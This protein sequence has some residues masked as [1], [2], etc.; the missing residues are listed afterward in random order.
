MIG[1]MVLLGKEI[2][3][4]ELELQVLK[5]VQIQLVHGPLW[6]YLLTTVIQILL[7]YLHMELQP[8]LRMQ[9][10][11]MMSVWTLTTMWVNAC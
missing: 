10:S 6:I 2:V 4:K 1:V 9:K 7:R 5:N 3:L 8:H 11:G